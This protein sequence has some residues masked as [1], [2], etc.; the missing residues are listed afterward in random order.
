MIFVGAQLIARS[1]SYGYISPSTMEEYKK[2]IHLFAAG[3]KSLKCIR[4][5]YFPEKEGVCDLTQ[6]KAQEQIFVLANRSNQTIKVG[7]KGLEIVANF[8]DIDELDSWYER[9]KEQKRAYK[10]K[11]KEEAA[12]KEEERQKAPRAVLI[13]RRKAES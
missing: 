3:A 8:I 1:M 13:R 12:K 7:K 5:H 10:A 11:L 4:S 2:R 9:L 6:E